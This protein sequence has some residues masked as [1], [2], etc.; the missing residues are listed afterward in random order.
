MP[1]LMARGLSPE[2]VTRVR[3]YARQHPDRSTSD[4][5]AA[6]L[7]AGLQITEARQKGAA[8]LHAGLTTAE[9]SAKGRHA[10][11]ARWDRH[12]AS[13]DP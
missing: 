8:M 10:V 3:Q 13:Q 6:L 1:T 9:R 2:L 7:E 4:S 5:I 11:T 12:H